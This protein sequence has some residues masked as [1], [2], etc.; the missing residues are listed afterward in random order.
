M[1]KVMPMNVIHSL[2]EFEDPNHPHAGIEQLKTIALGLH[3]QLGKYPSV[4]GDME[5]QLIADLTTFAEKATK[6]QEVVLATKLQ[7]VCAWHAAHWLQDSDEM[8]FWWNT[9][10]D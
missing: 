6:G 8:G 7:A 9:F 2:L 4:F 5:D 10:Y 3:V 1:S